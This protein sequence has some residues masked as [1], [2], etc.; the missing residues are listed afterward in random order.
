M[1]LIVTLKQYIHKK[2]IAILLFKLLFLKTKKSNQVLNITLLGTKKKN[3]KHNF[4]F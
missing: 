2:Q 3:N 1:V 4:G